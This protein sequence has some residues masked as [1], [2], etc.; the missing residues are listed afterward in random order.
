M[1]IASCLFHISRTLLLTMQ[2]WSTIVE[3]MEL[4]TS[5]IHQDGHMKGAIY[6]RM[7]GKFTC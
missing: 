1:T 6:H 2:I 7:I 3:I 4:A 5:T